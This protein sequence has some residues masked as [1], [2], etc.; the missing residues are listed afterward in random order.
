[1][2]KHKVTHPNKFSLPAMFFVMGLIL[3]GCKNKSVYEKSKDDFY[4]IDSTV[5]KLSVLKWNKKHENVDSFNLMIDT[6][7]VFPHE[8]VSKERNLLNSIIYEDSSAWFNPG[9][10]N[11]HIIFQKPIFNKFPAS[12][13]G[14]DDDEIA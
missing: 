9:P 3:W 6:T 4:K 13:Q 7:I 5:S 2:L 14:D 11:F 10:E 1:M 12:L 8:I